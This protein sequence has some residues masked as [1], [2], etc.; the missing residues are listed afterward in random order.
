[1]ILAQLFATFFK[2][3]I[4]N[5]L[6]S[7]PSAVKVNKFYENIALNYINYD[8]DDDSLCHPFYIY[9]VI[10]EARFGMEIVVVMS[11]RIVNAWSRK[12]TYAH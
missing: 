10:N 11:S 4:W 7:S 8:T 1:M 3:V 12:Q 9:L 6:K 2:Y 5:K